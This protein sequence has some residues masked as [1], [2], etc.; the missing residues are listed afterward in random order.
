MQDG[1][2]HVYETMQL[3]ISL[4]NTSQKE[5]QNTAVTSIAKTLCA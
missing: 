5:V 2:H 1:I 3:R 4:H